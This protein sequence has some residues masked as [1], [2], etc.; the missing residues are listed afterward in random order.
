MKPA[1]GHTVKSSQTQ[2]WPQSL[3]VRQLHPML[4][5]AEMRELFLASGDKKISA[6]SIYTIDK[7][8]ISPFSGSKYDLFFSY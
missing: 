4:E 7:P 1:N 3:L 2:K 5:L 6:V 8:S